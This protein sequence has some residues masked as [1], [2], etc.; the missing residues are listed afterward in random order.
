MASNN[1]P[2]TRWM[3]DLDWA[4]VSPYKSLNE[5]CTIQDLNALRESID[6]LREQL[7]DAEGIDRIDILTSLVGYDLR[8]K[9][10]IHIMLKELIPELRRIHHQGYDIHSVLVD[11][12]HPFCNQHHEALAGFALHRDLLRH[13]MLEE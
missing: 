4:G 10:L 7:D 11:D 2:K 5:S 8:S 1:Q 9:T 12:D 13:L 3:S 6:D